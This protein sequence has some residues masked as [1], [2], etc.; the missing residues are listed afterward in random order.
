MPKYWKA[1]ISKLDNWPRL[2]Q[3][4]WKV[5]DNTGRLIVSKSE[6]IKPQNFEIPYEAS[7]V[8]GITTD[9]ANDIGNDINDVLENF[10]NQVNQSNTIIAHNLSFDEKV[11]ASELYRL[12]ILNPFSNKEKICTME[13]STNICKI[14][15]NYGYKWPKLQELYYHLCASSNSSPNK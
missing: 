10:M 13:K 8:H 11:I 9:L 4:A 14:E 15:G 3:I 2:V 1:P 6:I 5:Y 7:K 12:N